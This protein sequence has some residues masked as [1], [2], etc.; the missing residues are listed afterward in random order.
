MEILTRMSQ[1]LTRWIP[2][3]APFFDRMTTRDL[4]RRFTASEA[5]GFFE[6]HVLG[7]DNFDLLELNE[8]YTSYDVYDRWDGLDPRFVEKWASFR[9]PPIP[10]HIRFLRRLCEHSWGYRLVTWARLTGR[11]VKR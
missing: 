8:D 3:F 11:F 7:R 10:L 6:K 1:H 4:S 5:L 2:I 9:E